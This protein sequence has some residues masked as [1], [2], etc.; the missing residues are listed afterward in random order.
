VFLKIFAQTSAGLLAYLMCLSAEH[1][2]LLLAAQEKH[3]F[4]YCS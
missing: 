3:P 2:L 4:Y 1:F